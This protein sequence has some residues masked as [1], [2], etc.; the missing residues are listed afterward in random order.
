MH[1]IAYRP[2]DK[3]AFPGHIQWSGPN[4]LLSPPECRELISR[5]DNDLLFGSVGSPNNFRTEH[6]TRCVELKMLPI[7]DPQLGWFYERIN[8]RVQLANEAF[9]DFNLI[10]LLEPAQFLKYT[11]ARENKPDGHYGWH[12]DFGEGAMGTRKLSVVIQLS[13]PTEYEG[14]RLRVMSHVEEEMAYVGQGEGVMFPSWAPHHVTP[15]TR[16]T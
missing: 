9:Y 15:I 13:E 2:R 12:Q 14:C 3:K 7:E 6:A 4:R 5:F 11:P 16:G 1:G 8:E 10:G